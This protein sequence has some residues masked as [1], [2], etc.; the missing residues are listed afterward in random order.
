M[1][2][3]D[4]IEDYLFGESYR[5]EAKISV[6]DLRIVF[7][8]KLGMCNGENTTEKPATYC[9]EYG[10]LDFARYLIR[11]EAK[12][13]SSDEGRESTLQIDES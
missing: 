3:R 1:C 13:I 10:A 5:P 9:L 6:A 11:S 4:R 2:I 7:E 12:T 8:E